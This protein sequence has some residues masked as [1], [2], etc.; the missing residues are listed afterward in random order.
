MNKLKSLKVLKNVYK[1]LEDPTNW[2]T[3]FSARDTSNS[4]IIPTDPNACQWCLLGA[5]EKISHEN[6][7]PNQSL[8]I[9]FF[10]RDTLDGHTVFPTSVPKF[11]DT[12]SHADVL[13]F[14]KLNI[15]KLKEQMNRDFGPWGQTKGN[16]YE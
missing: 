2:T 7:C 3:E 11:N 13:Y 15:V 8:A 4:P 16:S 1:L 9:S 10:L 14:L 12:H 6:G 5:V